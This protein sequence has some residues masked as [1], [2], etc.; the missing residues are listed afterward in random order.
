LIVAGL[1]LYFIF[2]CAILVTAQKKK[3]LSWVDLTLPVVVMVSWFILVI[4]GYGHQSI[5]HIV[6]VPFALTISLVLFIA[7]VFI[8]DRFF[9]NT[10]RNSFVVVIL[11]VTT[12]FLLR[13]FMPFLPE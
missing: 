5:T 2:V 4:S 8:F 9:P 6:E 12:V 10:K 1:F 7:K 3:T 13:T 11:S